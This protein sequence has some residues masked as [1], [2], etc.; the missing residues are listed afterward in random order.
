[1]RPEWEPIRLRHDGLLV[2][3]GSNLATVHFK[4]DILRAAAAAAAFSAALERRV[5][6]DG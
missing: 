2:R 6:S 4:S 3:L 1:M 5:H